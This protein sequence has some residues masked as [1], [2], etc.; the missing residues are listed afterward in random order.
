MKKL[1]F[2]CAICFLFM[3]SST[4][5]V[6]AAETSRISMKYNTN[7]EEPD[8]SSYWV[9]ISSSGQHT[10]FN[11]RATDL[12]SPADTLSNDDI[13]LYDRSTNMTERVSVKYNTSAGEPDSFSTY[14]SVSADG[15]YVVFNSGATDLVN[16][17]DSLG[18][19]DVF[20][21]DRVAGSTE[22]ISVNTSGGEPDNWSSNPSVSA[23]GRY[24]VFDSGATDLVSPSDSLSHGDVFLR[25]RVSGTT[26]RV[27]VKYN[28]SAGEPDGYSSNPSVSADGRYV[29]FQSSATDLVNPSDSLSQTDIFLRDRVVGSTERISVNTNGGEPNNYS[30]QSSISANGRYIV[31]LSFASDLVDNDNNGQNDVFIYD[32]ILQ[33]TER[34][35][36]N[37]AG[38]EANGQT[39]TYGGAAL[40]SDG[41]YVAFTSSATNLVEND[42]NAAPDVFRRD[43]K[44]GKV[45]R[46]S[47]NTNGEEVSGAS[48]YNVEM[49]ANGRFIVFGSTAN[50]LVEPNDPG[51]TTDIFMR[52]EDK[53]F[54][55][56]LFLN[57]K[58]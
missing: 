24:V 38:E 43:R 7:G 25:D 3:L 47:V 6:S 36:V 45:I 8:D 57:K 56:P 42:N 21:R 46:N 4:V 20:L 40:S 44:I 15:R 37:D 11:S 16:P 34:V 39:S 33:T 18:N 54:Y 49:S 51:T 5:F 27:S 12:V 23:D 14:P 1:S 9:S 19:S 13:F 10:V 52:A 48:P 58:K 17:P 32:R 53:E 55:W 29:V 30:S 28:T 41:R 26:E 2:S 50:D 22:R 31:Y 35:N